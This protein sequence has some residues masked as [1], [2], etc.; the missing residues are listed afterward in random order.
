MAVSSRSLIADPGTPERRS[1]ADRR[2]PADVDP[3]RLS[4]AASEGGSLGTIGEMLA[5]L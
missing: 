2:R 1:E 3:S 4:V 5:E